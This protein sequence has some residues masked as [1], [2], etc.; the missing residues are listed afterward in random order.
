MKVKN[1]ISTSRVGVEVLTF[2]NFDIMFNGKS[3]FKSAGRKYKNLELLKYFITNRNKKIVPENIIDYFWSDKE[4]GDPKNALSTQIHRLKKSLIELNLMKPPGGMDAPYYFELNFVNGFY[5]FSIGEN[6][7]IDVE[8]YKEKTLL[9]DSMKTTDPEEAIK[10]YKDV[11]DIYKGQYMEENVYSEWA[12]TAR[13]RYHRTYIQ[14]VLQL[15]ELLKYYG[16]YSEIVE[17]FEDIVS[18][19]PYEEGFHIYFLEALIEL[20]EFRYALSHYNYLATKMYKDIGVRP[21]SAL[22]KIHRKILCEVD[23][24]EEVDAFFIDKKLTDEELLEGSIFCEVDF[25]KFAYSLEKR[26][27]TRYGK[28]SVLMIITLRGADS[29]TKPQLEKAMEV[30]RDVL[31][32]SLRK[33]DLVT[34]WNQNQILILLLNIEEKDIKIINRRIEQK[35]IASVDKYMYE[36]SITYRNV[37][38]EV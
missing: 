4:Y 17:I 14:S 21:S 10:N 33:S 16:R 3:V 29:V 35:F 6:C 38:T 36:L 13:N 31:W 9:A 26:K 5:V 24:N 7:T 2:G 37:T 23:S 18:I 32:L 27:S 8:L 12:V 25:F 20:G 34:R 28:N 22:K 30:L 15:M 11:I 19:E 1:V